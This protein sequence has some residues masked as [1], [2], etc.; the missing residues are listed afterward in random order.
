MGCTQSKIENE[1]AVA[2]CK[3]RKHFMKEAVSARNAFAAAHSSYAVYLKNTG[4]ALSDYA[5]GEVQNPQ[6][7]HQAQP[8]SSSSSSSSTVAQAAQ[9][10]ETLP[11]PPPPPSNFAPPAPLQ[12][13]A[14]MPE[15]KIPMSDPP[16]RPKPIME[17]DEDAEEDEIDN[18]GS[19]NLRRRR[20]SRSGSR[21]GHREVVEEVSESNRTPPPV[22]RTIQPSYQQQDNYSYDYF[23]NVETMPRPTLS[24]VEEDNISKEEIDRNMF[25]ER[26]KRVDDEE[27]VV[28]KSSAKVE[29][30]PVPE[31]SVEAPLP[32]PDPAAAAAAAAAVAAK[33]LKKA[34]QVGP[35]ATEGKRTVNTNVNLLQIFVELDDHFL[36]ASESAHEVSKMLEATRL[37][38]HSNFADNRGNGIDFSHSFFISVGLKMEK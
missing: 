15:I 38:Y 36:K 17:E 25:D 3:E 6:L 12:R 34:K 20:S 24:E 33:S 32:P 9:F 28:V 7:A 10:V 11:P 31:K 1:E 5:Q 23:F 4:A 2:R 16:P 8:N 19:V 18:E 35:G 22:N 37:H 29:A 26:P 13:A 27:E 30:E 21:G 14:T